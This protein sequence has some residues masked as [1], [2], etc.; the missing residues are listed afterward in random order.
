MHARRWREQILVVSGPGRACTRAIGD[1]FDTLDWVEM[2]LTKLGRF[3][4]FRQEESVGRRLFSFLCWSVLPR[5]AH[6]TCIKV[7]IH[8]RGGVLKVTS[9]VDNDTTV[10][11][12]HTSTVASSPQS[13]SSVV[14]V[15]I[16]RHWRALREWLKKTIHSIWHIVTLSHCHCIEK[17]GIREWRENCVR[18]SLRLGLLQ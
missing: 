3:E 13:W 8:A 16:I 9:A 5:F 18:N 1:R 17:S 6:E 11:D 10:H 15:F 4:L 14:S 12:V 2:Q 7:A